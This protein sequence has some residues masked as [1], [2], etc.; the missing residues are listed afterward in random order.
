[1][2]QNMADVGVF[3]AL[4]VVVARRRGDLP[5]LRWWRAGAAYA[6]GAIVTMS[7]VAGWTLLHGT[8]L[9]GV[10]DAMYP[11][12]VDAGRVIA[13]SS[14]RHATA[15]MWIL[16]GSWAV[17]GGAVIIALTAWALVSRRLRGAATWGLVATLGF[18]I[19]SIGLGG[20]YWHH[21]LVQLV[22][23]TAVTCGLLVASRQRDYKV[24]ETPG[25][26]LR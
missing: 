21:Y 2:K 14:H 13:S 10:F 11:F 5:L 25:A 6:V 8:S 15:R 19:F 23:P 22:V 9:V 4:T 12:R 16:L 3:A 18:D 17:S 24:R 26:V 1:M 7:A 20:N